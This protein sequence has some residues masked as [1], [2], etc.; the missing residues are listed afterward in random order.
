M[1]TTTMMIRN[2]RTSGTGPGECRYVEQDSGQATSATSNAWRPRHAGRHPHKWSPGVRSECGA[3]STRTCGS[4]EAEVLRRERRPVVEARVRNSLG[5]P[6]LDD[7][8]DPDNGRTRLAQRLDRGEDGRAGCR[9]V[10]DRQ[11]APAGDVGAF[12]PPLE[13]VRL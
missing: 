1:A 11:H 10:L 13:P 7:D 9:R 12:D 2:A 5:R 4:G 3:V 6:S 8:G